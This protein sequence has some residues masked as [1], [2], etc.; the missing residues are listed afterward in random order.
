MLILWI[1]SIIFWLYSESYF[2]FIQ[3]LEALD[4]LYQRDPKEQESTYSLIL[5][6]FQKFWSPGVEK[7]VVHDQNIFC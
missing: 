6:M 7:T 3:F 1:C 2:L 4:S 5:L